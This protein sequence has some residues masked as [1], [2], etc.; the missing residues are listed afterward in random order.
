[1]NNFCAIIPVYNHP[2]HLVEL[3]EYFQRL[4]IFVI[5]VDDGSCAETAHVIDDIWQQKQNEMTCIRHPYN[6]G[7]GAAIKT[8]IKEAQKL[9]FSHAIQID[10]DGQHAWQDV[11]EFIKVS[12]QYPERIIIGYPVYD[13]SVDK[14]K[15]LCTLFNTCL[16]LD[17]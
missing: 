2:Q 11:P 9:G 12:E 15:V 13:E 8:G 4:N 6:Q 16:G 3:V 1:M 5:M 14:K 7:K 10:A 17:K